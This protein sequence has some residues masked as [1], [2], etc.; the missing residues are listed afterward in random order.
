MARQRRRTRDGLEVAELLEDQL[1]GDEV[2]HAAGGRVS[3]QRAARGQHANRPEHGHNRA[4][5][6]AQSST[7][8]CLASFRGPLHSRALHISPWPLHSRALQP[9]PDGHLKRDAAGRCETWWVKPLKAIMARRAC[10]ISASWYRSRFFSLEPCELI[11][12]E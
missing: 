1:L 5:D 8:S 3:E 12:R 2:L 11:G 7:F 4:S 9:F 10:L 6:F